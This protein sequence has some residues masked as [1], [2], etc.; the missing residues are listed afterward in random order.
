VI[1]DGVHLG[2]ETMFILVRLLGLGMGLVFDN[3]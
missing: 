1:K 3:I 2:L